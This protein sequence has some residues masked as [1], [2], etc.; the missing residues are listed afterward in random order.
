[1]LHGRLPHQL[2]DEHGQHHYT[3]NAGLV[4]AMLPGACERVRTVPAA[5]GR[6]PRPHARNVAGI[7]VVVWER[8]AQVTLFAGDDW[9]INRGEH[10]EHDRDDPPTAR[11]DLYPSH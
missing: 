1:M 6:K 9:D 11:R 8:L 10:Q 4:F 5:V 7:V 2:D 3:A